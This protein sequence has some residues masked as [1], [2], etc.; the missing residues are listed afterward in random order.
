MQ[1]ELSLYETRCG[2]LYDHLQRL[3]CYPNNVGDYSLSVIQYNTEELSAEQSKLNPFLMNKENVGK[4]IEIY[5]DEEHCQEILLILIPMVELFTNLY[6]QLEDKLLP[7][8]HFRIF[9][10]ENIVTQANTHKY[11]FVSSVQV[12]FTHLH[13]LVAAYPGLTFGHHPMFARLFRHLYIDYYPWVLPDS[14]PDMVSHLNEP[15][16]NAMLGEAKINMANKNSLSLQGPKIESI[17]DFLA[18]IK[19]PMFPNEY[20]VD[21]NWNVLELNTSISPQQSQQSVS[22]PFLVTVEIFPHNENQDGIPTRPPTQPILE[23]FELV[24]ISIKRQ[25]MVCFEG[26]L[27]LSMYCC[28]EGFVNCLPLKGRHFWTQY[29]GMAGLLLKVPYISLQGCEIVFKMI[30]GLLNRLNE[31]QLAQAPASHLR[32]FNGVISSFCHIAPS[33]LTIL[34][35]RLL[36]HLYF[37]FLPSIHT[38][39]VNLSQ[40]EGYGTMLSKFNDILALTRS[41]NHPVFTLF[42]LLF[43]QYSRWCWFK[44]QDERFTKAAVDYNNNNQD[45]VNQ[46]GPECGDIFDFD[47]KFFNQ[48]ITTDNNAF[49]IINLHIEATKR[50]VINVEKIYSIPEILS[51][52]PSLSASS[53]LPTFFN[54]LVKMPSLTVDLHFPPFFPNSINSIDAGNMTLSVAHSYHRALSGLNDNG[55][56][57]HTVHPRLSTNLIR[58]LISG[59]ECDSR[60]EDFGYLNSI[61]NYMELIKTLANSPQ[62]TFFNELNLLLEYAMGTRDESNQ[63]IASETEIDYLSPTYPTQPHSLNYRANYL[64]QRVMNSYVQVVT[65]LCIARRQATSPSFEIPDPTLFYPKYEPF[66]LSNC[67][68]ILST[69]L[70]SQYGSRRLIYRGVYKNH[71]HPSKLQFSNVA[72]YD[73]YTHDSLNAL[74]KDTAMNIMPL[75]DEYTVMRHHKKIKHVN[76]PRVSNNLDKLLHSIH[77][78]LQ[79]TLNV[80]YLNIAPTEP[81]KTPVF[82]VVLEMDEKDNDETMEDNSD[83]EDDDDDDHNDDNDDGDDDGDGDNDNNIEERQPLIELTPEKIIT[84]QKRD[85]FLSH[86][87]KFSKQHGLDKLFQSGSNITQNDILFMSSEVLYIVNSFTHQNMGQNLFFLASSCHLDAKNNGFSP[88][89]PF[90]FLNSLDNLHR[91]IFQPNVLVSP[92]IRSLLAPNSSSADYSFLINSKTAELVNLS[93]LPESKQNNDINNQIDDNFIKFD[94][95]TLFEEPVPAVTQTHWYKKQHPRLLTRP[96]IALYVET[97]VF[98]MMGFS[99]CSFETSVKNATF[100]KL[101]NSPSPAIPNKGK[102]IYSVGNSSLVKAVQVRKTWELEQ[103]IATAVKSG[104]KTAAKITTDALKKSIV[105]KSKRLPGSRPNTKKP[106][107]LDS[108]ELHNS[109]VFCDQNVSSASM[110]SNTAAEI[111]YSTEITSSMV[112]FCIE[113]FIDLLLVP[114][115]WTTVR[116]LDFSAPTLPPSYIPLSTSESKIMPSLGDIIEPGNDPHGVAI[117]QPS[118]IE[119]FS[120]RNPLKNEI[121][122]SQKPQ[123]LG[124]FNALPQCELDAIYHAVDFNT[125]IHLSNCRDDNNNDDYK[126]L[127]LHEEINLSTMMD[128]GDQKEELDHRNKFPIFGPQRVKSDLLQQLQSNVDENDRFETLNPSKPDQSSNKPQNRNKHIV[129]PSLCSISPYVL[130]RSLQRLAF[131]GMNS[132]CPYRADTHPVVSST[133]FDIEGDISFVGTQLLEL[134]SG[135]IVPVNEIDWTKPYCIKPS[136]TFWSPDTI[137]DMITMHMADRE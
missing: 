105:S 23:Q 60:K 97:I 98:I 22:K 121:L 76:N 123:H 119:S 41:V 58:L 28:T 125:I 21:H 34:F 19:S 45:F 114:D 127:T 85:L 6:C 130:C 59:L 104:P 63:L 18:H 81:V 20:N 92:S 9:L 36:Q 8:P 72:N 132:N 65:Q 32:F 26:L 100:S 133:S 109:R 16:F 40:L 87:S 107:M 55:R 129:P 42:V 134:D 128:D 2:E 57:A 66:Y 94:V 67:L 118:N 106:I 91:F 115:V 113:S 117:F 53:K 47:A 54:E 70:R 17:D 12:I 110:R 7:S 112:Q 62:N 27:D 75:E 15:A 78:N 24:P 35:N 1:G 37:P 11:T 124:F 71:C 108:Y 137:C 77:T 83:N 120:G 3:M 64:A 56:V 69:L 38:S 89:S 88:I 4:M 43:Q 126:P 102:H 10:S 14:V 68:P 51:P 33:F 82:E 29:I 48:D 99:H 122:V 39:C 46:I 5:Q 74:Y 31:A 90:T 96:L 103:K 101:Y 61:S 80:N 44:L 111:E 86:F 95:A 131:D 73:L 136:T 79:F 50:H 13:L 135:K 25:L 49:G 30:L 84:Q 116:T 93:S 52:P